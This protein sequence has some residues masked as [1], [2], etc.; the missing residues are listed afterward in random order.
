MDLRAAAQVETH[1]LREFDPDRPAGGKKGD[2]RRA[3]AR[4]HREFFRAGPALRAIGRGA[5]GEVAVKAH[6]QP[7]RLRARRARILRRLNSRIER[8][9]IIFLARE[10]DVEDHPHVIGF[11]LLTQGLL[12]F[13]S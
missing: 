7:A 3:D 10:G 12:S 5:H 6:R 13:G 1:E 8:V 11:E 4:S 2:D 9:E